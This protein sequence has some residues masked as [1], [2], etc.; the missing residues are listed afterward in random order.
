MLRDIAL[1]V[2][3]QKM[4]MMPLDEVLSPRSSVLP[5]ELRQL[6]QAAFDEASTG[7]EVIS[8]AIPALRPPGEAASMFE[9]LSI[10]TQNS[11][12]ILEEAERETNS[13]RAGL[14][15]SVERANTLALQISAY[16]ALA[17]E[18]GSSDPEVVAARVAIER[19]LEES[20][21]MISLRGRPATTT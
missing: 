13:A 21:G 8:V 18:K 11:M 16:K 5:T 6:I 1:R 3:T 9:E 15:G 19:V 4:S 10:D 14:V 12:K 2:V 17:S 20:Q 7:I